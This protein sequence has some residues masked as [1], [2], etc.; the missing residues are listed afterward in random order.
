MTPT[1]R[2]SLSAAAA[3]FAGVLATFVL[4]NPTQWQAIFRASESQLG[5]WNSTLP[6][7]VAVGCVLAVVACAVLL[8][9]ASA[10]PAWIAAVV[11]TAVLIAARM[12]V[13]GASDLDQLRLLYYAKC[14]AGGVL[15]GAAVAA[16]WSRPIPRLVLVAA[17]GSTFVVAHTADA[18]TPSTSVLGEPFWWILIPALVLAVACAAV[19]DA[20]PDRIDRDTAIGVIATAATL[21]LAHRVLGEW[22]ERQTG[23]QFRQWVVIALCLVLVVAL[24]EFWARRLSSPFLLAATAVAAVTPFV[25]TVLGQDYLR[26][27]PWVPVAVGVVA[28]VVGVAISRWRPAPT[29]AV[30]VLALVPLSVLI[31]PG[32]TDNR[33]WL[34]VQLAVLGVG[35]GLALGATLPDH[36]ATAALGLAV[37][38]LALVFTEVVGVTTSFVIYSGSYEPLPG[39]PLSTGW[40]SISPT[41]TFDRA[42]AVA[43]L[44]VVVFCALAIRG[45]R[46]HRSAPRPE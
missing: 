17:A 27:R 39:V 18:W 12:M 9:A 42:A 16:V 7:G 43:L 40:T 13:P 37:P 11:A 46:T 15:L 34:L 41:T 19:D 20:V 6:T 31:A 14:L 10:R 21:A 25:A 2:T 4:V 5:S 32:A 29:I 23:S 33:A 3:A 26:I 8:R 28:V 35:I 44:L 45:L 24:A 30:A 36:A 22:I 1:V 38:L